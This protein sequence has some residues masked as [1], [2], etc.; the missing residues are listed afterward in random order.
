MDSLLSSALY[1]QMSEDQ[2]RITFGSKENCARVLAAQ[3]ICYG[4]LRI[5]EALEGKKP[6]GEGAPGGTV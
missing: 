4:L 2:Y 1:T 5:A 6:E 3:Y